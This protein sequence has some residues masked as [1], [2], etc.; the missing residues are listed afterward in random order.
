MLDRRT[1]C[2][3]C[4]TTG[5]GECVTVLAHELPTRT[6][7]VQNVASGVEPVRAPPLCARFPSETGGR[8]LRE[9]LG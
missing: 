7:E 4:S 2:A 5:Y 1:C 9:R 6:L 8:G 3:C